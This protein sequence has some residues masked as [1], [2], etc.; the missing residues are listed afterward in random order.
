LNHN[1]DSAA[2]EEDGLCDYPQTYYNCQ[3]ECLNDID[4]NGVCDEL[5][6]FGCTDYSAVNYD[7][8]ATSDNNSCISQEQA[9]IDS[10]NNV[11]NEMHSQLLDANSPLLID[12]IDGWNMIGYT[13]KTAQDVVLGCQD[14]ND[15]ILLLKNNGGD[16]YF[17]EFDFNGV[18]E[19]L[20]GQGYLLKVTESYQDFTFPNF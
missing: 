18:G 15:I 1:Y 9:I 12:L 20:P 3:G 7:P 5:E 6:I 10:L 14:I 8:S 4:S 16:A 19:L 17:P 11:I 2:T 13:N